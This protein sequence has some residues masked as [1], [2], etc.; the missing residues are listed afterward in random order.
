M[1]K[2]DTEFSVK[3]YP[4]GIGVRADIDYLPFNPSGV[5]SSRGKIT[6]FSRNS[7]RRLR[8]QLLTQFVPHKQIYS[9][10]F[11][12]PSV[13]TPEEWR[14][15]INK[16]NNT[17]N[18]YGWA[19]VWRVELQRRGTPHLHCVIWL[20]D[21]FLVDVVKEKWVSLVGGF[22]FPDMACVFSSGLDSKWIMY[23]T[24]HISKH[25][26]E[27]LGWQGRQW[28]VWC[29]AL[30]EE[31]LI[32][33]IQLSEREYYQFNRACRGWLKSKKCSGR[34]NSPVWYRIGFN[35]WWTSKLVDFIQAE[36]YQESLIKEY[37]LTL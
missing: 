14:V 31:C 8:L 15:L 4:F 27:Q 6:E 32:D 36:V 26:K 29:R 3:I 34:L 5:G 9:F 22:Q 10:T 2:N 18:Y 19:G 28:G 20:S 17:C 24:A 30:F 1:G 11:T 37:T 25:K 12:T 33:E 23:I 21:D 16:W 7:S 13:F 35:S